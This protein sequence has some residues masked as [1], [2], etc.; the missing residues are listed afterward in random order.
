MKIVYLGAFS[1]PH[2]TEC[3]IANAFER[4]G[5]ELVRLEETTSDQ[6]S[7][8]AACRRHEPDL[9]L[10][11][12][13]RFR[14]ANHGWPDD[15]EPIRRMIAA[16]RP[17]VGR[18]VCWVF[19]LLAREFRQER[20]QWAARVAEACDSFATTD[21]ATAPQL[22]N[23]VVIRQGM[24]DDVDR[25]C[26]WRP[27]P[28]PIGGDV[29]FLGCAYQDR[30]VLVEALG[31]RF[32]GASRFCVVNNVRSSGLTRLVRSYRFVVGP[33]YPYFAGYWSNRL[34]VVTGHGGLFAAPAV[35]G[36]DA[37]GWLPG[38]NYL[39]LPL[40]PRAMA[41]QLEE[42]LRW[43][44]TSLDEIRRTGFEHAGTACTYDRRV[45]ELLKHLAGAGTMKRSGQ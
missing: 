6:A 31:R 34:Y 24:P 21:G 28:S 14:E 3:Y 19:D 12:K 11:A 17:H 32:S 35:Q 4:L 16:V 43:D 44:T 15:A 22:P 25:S 30:Q 39:E 18:V 27:A 9:L 5:H 33:H 2:N 42:Y 1:L 36:M 7:I 26:P 13:A 20:F 40:E 29:L 23:A 37:E 10:F 38:R 8:V 41:A 45:Q